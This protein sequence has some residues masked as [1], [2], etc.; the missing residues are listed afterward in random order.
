ML[1]KLWGF[2]DK[3]GGSLKLHYRF[4]GD[5]LRTSLFFNLSNKALL[6]LKIL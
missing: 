3:L 5:F 6:I 1:E 2:E 4:W